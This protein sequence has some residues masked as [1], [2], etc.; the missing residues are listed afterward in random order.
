MFMK[1]INGR[2]FDAVETR[3]C[4]MTTII[5]MLRKIVMHVEDL[6]L[7]NDAVSSSDYPALSGRMFNEMEWE[8]HDL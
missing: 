2:Q 5:P 1:R 7:F 6:G 8:I 3:N 4:V